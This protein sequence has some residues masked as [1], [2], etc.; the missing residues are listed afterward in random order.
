MFGATTQW[1]GDSW[2][3]YALSER[4]SGARFMPYLLGGMR[5]C[6]CVK[7]WLAE[8]PAGRP[9]LVFS[10]GGADG[11]RIVCRMPALGIN[12]CYR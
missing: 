7:Y 11:I 8:P 12:T 10:R 4:V 2:G 1:G 9:W 3:V 6:A 5:S